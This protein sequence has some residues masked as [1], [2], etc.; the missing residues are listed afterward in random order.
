[1][2]VIFFVICLFPGQVAWLLMDFGNSGES[3]EK[4]I[5]IVLAFSDILDIL[6][7]CVNPVIYCLLKA[8]YRKEYINCLVCLFRGN[9]EN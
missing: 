1:M 9:S 4:A 2:V 7:A 3:Q 6:H 8:R 5:D